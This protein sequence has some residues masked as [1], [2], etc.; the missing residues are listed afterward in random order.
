MLHLQC[1]SRF[2]FQEFDEDAKIKEEI[3]LKNQHLVYQETLKVS[4][5]RPVN[6]CDVA[7]LFL[8]PVMI[9]VSERK[10]GR[11]KVRET[12]RVCRRASHERKGVSGRT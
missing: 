2:L 3:K 5:L 6:Q 1:N 11:G 10:G 8:K 7:L 4:L 9:C 12:K